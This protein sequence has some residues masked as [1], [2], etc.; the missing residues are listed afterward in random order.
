MLHVGEGE[1]LELFRNELG[2]LASLRAL[3]R[4]DL[5]IRSSDVLSSCMHKCAT[6][7]RLIQAHHAQMPLPDEKRPPKASDLIKRFQSHVD[8]AKE[9]S[10]TPQSASSTPNRPRVSS[11]DFKKAPASP[12]GA[13]PQPK[14]LADVAKESGRVYGEPAEDGSRPI[15][16]RS[17][18]LSEPPAKM[19]EEE[20]K[21]LHADDVEFHSGS[22]SSPVTRTDLPPI[23]TSPSADDGPVP[24]IVPGS[25]SLLASPALNASSHG[26]SLSVES[27]HSPS[28]SRTLSVESIPSPRHEGLSQPSSP[29]TETG[30]LS[31]P[32][33]RHDSSPPLTTEGGSPTARSFNFDAGPLSMPDSPSPSPSPSPSQAENIENDANNQ[34]QDEGRASPPAFALPTGQQDQPQPDAEKE[35]EQAAVTSTTTA[36][37]PVAEQAPSTAS[38]QTSPRD[39][40]AK[41]VSKPAARASSSSSA[42]SRPSVPGSTRAPHSLSTPT[43]SF[44]AK[45]KP[46]V[47]ASS[48]SASPT[49]ARG[50]ASSANSSPALSQS[51]RMSPTSSRGSGRSVSTTA[52]NAGSP[53]L[54]GP[55]A[56]T[57]RMA[58]PSMSGSRSAPS[59]ASVKRGAAADKRSPV[60]TK[61]SSLPSAGGSASRP[62]GR[63]SSASPTSTRKDG[64]SKTASSRK[65][66]EA[67]SQ[68]TAN[69]SSAATRGGKPLRMA[70][71]GRIGLVGAHMNRDAARNKPDRPEAAKQTST[72]QQDEAHDD[73]PDIPDEDEGAQDGAD[74][75]EKVFQGF[76]G[77]R[78]FG[79]IPIPMQQ[80]TGGGEPRAMMADEVDRA[81][82]ALGTE[83][84]GGV[85]GGEEQA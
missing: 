8:A 27:F 77:G 13:S 47:S 21:K 32:P 54:S 85:A 72:N 35:A 73:I 48:P 22:P 28:H 64:A 16:F 25:A 84:S 30:R 36:P 6:C 43:A 24:D 19:T 12:N 49:R 69:G 83:T 52:S 71:R 76:G 20:D 2:P 17:A 42:A 58:G 81:N 3:D 1:L 66:T 45:T 68:A 4:L 5:S 29:A 7:S 33:L 63:A 56:S 51:A 61:P 44:L 53:S 41:S 70:T 10:S 74:A 78:P 79:R 62:S 67:S 39:S 14:T 9:A 59:S 38:A 23:V 57:S 26:R 15:F 46:K 65:A 18:G 82:E 40:S 50:S 60:V 75:G 80:E 37:E 11:H 55:G 31:V 34:K